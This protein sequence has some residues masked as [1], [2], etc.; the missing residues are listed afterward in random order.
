MVVVG[1]TIRLDRVV[2]LAKEELG[3][4]LEVITVKTAELK[5]AQT[6]SKESERMRTST[7]RRW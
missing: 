2:N 5:Y 3:L 4:A 7:G 1:E 6:R